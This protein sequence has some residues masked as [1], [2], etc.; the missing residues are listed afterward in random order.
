MAPHSIDVQKE[1]L[2]LKKCEKNTHTG[3]SAKGRFIEFLKIF[4]NIPEP[5]KILDVGGNFGT[6]RWFKEK[7]PQAKVTIL[8]NSQKEL[9]SYSPVICQN[10]QNFSVKEKYDLVFAGEII[11][12]LYNPDGLIASCMLALK[13]GGYFVITAPNLA[14]F[15]N[16]IFL[17][18]GWTPG[19][20]APS[21]RYLTGNPLLSNKITSF[22]TIGDHKSM[23]TWRG[24][25]ELLGRYG[26][27]I[28]CGYGYS[29]GQEEK[30]RAIGN[31]YY[32]GP[33]GKLRL[34]LN[35]FL[36]TKLKEGMMFVCQSPR[37]IKRQQVLK[38]ILKNDL[39][40]I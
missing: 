17:L 7:F 39:W 1:L 10:A 20:Y 29:Y 6:A 37:K 38:G 33:K 23:F 3:I 24:L 13:P 25:S 12:H 11:E 16:R 32:R 35:R 8:N 31:H 15:Y 36:P 2:L 5:Q 19:N 21:L 18:L 4:Q 26:F 30:L 22:G 28:I 27:K 14:C 40:E 34:F 9:S